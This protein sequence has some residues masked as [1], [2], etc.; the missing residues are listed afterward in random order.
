MVSHSANEY[1]LEHR[2]CFQCDVDEQQSVLSS[3]S[4]VIFLGG[5]LPFCDYLESD[6]ID[7]YVN[8]LTCEYQEIAV[9]IKYNKKERVRLNL[10]GG[11]KIVKT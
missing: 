10:P 9:N 3:L 11:T 5:M 4:I 1:E 6:N 7:K 2:M 8:C